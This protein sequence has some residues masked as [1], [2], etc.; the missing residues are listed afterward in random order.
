VRNIES[1]SDKKLVDAH[2]HP[3]PPCIVMERGEPLDLWAARAQPDRPQA[4]VVR[5]SSSSAPFRSIFLI[6]LSVNAATLAAISLHFK[7][8]LPG[9]CTVKLNFVTR[10]SMEPQVR[11][12]LW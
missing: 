1:N 5:T 11:R 12:N 6:I 10:C 2:G 8:L 9:I 4:F 7:P 3:L